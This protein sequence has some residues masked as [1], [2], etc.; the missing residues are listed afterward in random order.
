MFRIGFGYD[1]HKFKIN[2]ISTNHII[3]ICGIDIKHNRAIDAHSDGDVALHAA[4]DAIFGA[5]A[6]DD[7][8]T[9]F[10]ASEKQWYN[11]NSEIFLKEAVE[12]MNAENYKLGNIDIT[13]I[14]QKPKIEPH[15]NIMRENMA[16]I[17]NTN[18][19]NISIK[20]K[21]NEG[22]DSIGQELAIAAHV[23]VLCYKNNV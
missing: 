8:G 15:R 18:I 4:V 23:V 22:M 19:N 9:H 17:F 1:L 21:T 20:A 6:K 5:M 10:P 13:I 14:C 2:N 16:K 12:I 11:A 3:K 7:I